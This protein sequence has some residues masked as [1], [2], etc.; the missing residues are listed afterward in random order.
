MAPLLD[1]G[2]SVRHP[3]WSTKRLPRAVH[4][5][6][7]HRDPGQPPVP[8]GVR[9]DAT[10]DGASGPNGTPHAADEA[11][12]GVNELLDSAGLV[13]RSTGIAIPQSSGDPG[14]IFW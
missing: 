14:P 13:A 6:L 8:V 9:A 5:R 4:G 1:R 7:H 2:T 12:L 3:D 11:P 10:R